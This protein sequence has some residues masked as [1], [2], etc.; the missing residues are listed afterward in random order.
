MSSDE[1]KALVRHYLDQVWTKGNLEIIDKVIAQEYVQHA[2]GVPPGREGVHRFFAMI[3]SAFPD[4]HYS[5]DDLIAEGDKVVW[6]WTIRATHTGPFQGLSPTNRAVM[7]TG[8]SIV[9]IRDG[10][11]VEGWGEQDNLGMMQQL[12]AIPE[13]GQPE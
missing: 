7:I 1:N 11:F 9:K 8:M 2:R 10:K 12:G 3:R 6:C 13:P 5:V 4:A